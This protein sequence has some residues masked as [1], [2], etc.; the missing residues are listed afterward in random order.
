MKI[1]PYN[2]YRPVKHQPAFGSTD[3]YYVN[4]KGLEIGNNTWL[5]REDLDWDT[6]TEFEIGHFKNKEKVNIIQFAPS[7]GSEGYSKI[8]SLIGNRHR[9]NVDKFFPIQ[10]YDI[11]EHIISKARSGYLSLSEADRTRLKMHNVNFNSYFKRRDIYSEPKN[12]YYR[13]L[14]SNPDI[15]LGPLESFKVSEILT[16]KI[17]FQIGDMFELLP[18][19]KDEGNTILMCRNILGYFINPKIESF[20]RMANIVLKPGSLFQI[21]FLEEK[22]TPIEKYL[23]NNS[24]IKVMKN[25]FL[26]V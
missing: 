14:Q 15:L 6:L 26:K 3:R 21:G 4:E 16:N 19:I 1:F 24:F 18:K 17:N 9:K 8:M 22:H 10:A 5:F 23:K 20:V 13:Y 25:V 2:N 11:D 7:D 12:P